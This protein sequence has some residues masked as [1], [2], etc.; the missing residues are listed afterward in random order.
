MKDIEVTLELLVEYFSNKIFEYSIISDTCSIDD[1]KN[2]CRNGQ[3]E[4]GNINVFKGKIDQIPYL[5]VDMARFQKGD[6]TLI[7]FTSRLPPILYKG[8]EFL[9]EVEIPYSFKTFFDSC[10][11]QNNLIII[12]KVDLDVPITKPRFELDIGLKKIAYFTNCT[13]KTEVIVKGYESPFQSPLFEN[14]TFKQSLSISGNI[15]KDELFVESSKIGCFCKVMIVA[16]TRILSP[17]KFH[18]HIQAFA[19]KDSVFEGK[20][21]LKN[22]MTGENNICSVVAIYNT[23]F[24]KV[25]DFFQSH[26]GL[27]QFHRTIFEDFVGFEN[28]EF[29]L[30][31]DKTIKD[32]KYERLFETKED[33]Q[34]KPTIFD[35]VTIKELLNFRGASLH[36]GLDISTINI[37]NGSNF[38]GVS[39][40]QDDTK[41]ETNRII[42]NSFDSVGNFI[43]ANKFYV[44]ELK[45]H[46]KE[47]KYWKSLEDTLN[48][49]LLDINKLT[50]TFGTNYIK[51]IALIIMAS[52]F[53]FFIVYSESVKSE[54]LC[55]NPTAS[56]CSLYFKY[57]NE[58]S[59][60]IVPINSLFKSQDFHFLSFFYYLIFIVL[61]WQLIITL[62][63]N[64]KR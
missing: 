53:H 44:E 34:T 46:R 32:E 21:E 43:E 37:M 54:F 64:T 50:S 36:S 59:K 18:N 51:P 5:N 41:R 31:T 12:H 7:S 17:F 14:S 1:V 3:V 35:Y 25:S 40:N 42:K 2:Y 20:F 55:K 15:I 24:H 10:I 23:N 30:N 52:I 6:T 28:C 58:W 11:F 57:L 45:S 47:L 56:T 62:K 29:G 48:A 4:R 22:R 26:F 9:A 49:L 38:Y 63:R 13:F 61:S 8:C 27:V 19:C 16:D 33:A 39:I 60:S